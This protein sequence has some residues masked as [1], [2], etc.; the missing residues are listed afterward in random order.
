MERD[1][2]ER[3]STRNEAHEGTQQLTKKQRRE[4]GS[5]RRKTKVVLFPLSAFAL[6]IFWLVWQTTRKRGKQFL[7]FLPPMIVIMR[8]M[9]RKEE[10]KSW[11]LQTV[12]KPTLAKLLCLQKLQ[13]NESFCP[14]HPSC[15]VCPQQQHCVVLSTELLFFFF[16]S[17]FP[18]LLFKEAL[19][20]EKQQNQIGAPA[21]FQPIKNTN[22]WS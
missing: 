17:L 7:F 3:A 9:R 1:E 20:A 18:N 16:F 6:F 22:A 21:A 10:K 5:V 11:G 4:E 15:A 13:K 19:I 14:S 2:R 12:V 8:T